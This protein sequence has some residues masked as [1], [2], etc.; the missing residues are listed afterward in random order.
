MDEKT[1][2]TI[3]VYP[4][5]YEDGNRDLQVLINKNSMEDRNSS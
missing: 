4:L 1:K 2:I 3:Y 5:E